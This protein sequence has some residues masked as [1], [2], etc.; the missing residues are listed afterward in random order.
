MLLPCAD[1]E[2]KVQREIKA[3]HKDTQFCAVGLEAT[4]FGKYRA[5]CM[6]SFFL[7]FRFTRSC[8]SSVE[9]SSTWVHVSLFHPMVSSYRILVQYQNQK[10]DMD[11]KYMFNSVYFIT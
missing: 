5:T 4:R 8:K 10:V 1:E 2:A 7:A 11:I 6:I 3:L 9:S